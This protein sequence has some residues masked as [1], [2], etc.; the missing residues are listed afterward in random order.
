MGILLASGRLRMEKVAE[1]LAPHLGE[2]VVMVQILDGVHAGCARGFNIV[3]AIVEKEDV[4]G[5]SIEADGRVTIDGE[6]GLGEVEAVRPGAVVEVLQP[7]KLAEQTGVHGVAEVGEDA[8]ANAGELKLAGP[9]DHGLVGD[10]PEI[11]VGLDE[12]GEIFPREGGEAGAGGNLL[13]VERAGEVA[14][15][16]GVPVGPVLAMERGFVEGGGG[17]NAGPGGWVRGAGEDHAVVEE[18]CLDIADHD[19]SIV[20]S[21]VRACLKGGAS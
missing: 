19:G 8:G 20:P 10:G 13:P 11:G 12:G 6:L 9:V 4:L 16:V 1:A 17:S 7:R 14:A 21:G 15:I 3:E 2:E 5:S 18:D